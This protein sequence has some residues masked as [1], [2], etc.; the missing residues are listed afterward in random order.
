[1]GKAK[2]ERKKEKMEKIIE[3]LPNC[4]LFSYEKPERKNLSP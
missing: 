3:N 1:M 2:K 4:A